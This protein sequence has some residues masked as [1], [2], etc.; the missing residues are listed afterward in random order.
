MND[1][2]LSNFLLK[3]IAV[4]VT[5][6]IHLHSFLLTAEIA[7]YKIPDYHNNDGGYDDYQN[8]LCA[9]F[10]SRLLKRTLC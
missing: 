2:S 8:M 5:L 7:A 1:H 10:L 3:M 4:T 6:V 9:H